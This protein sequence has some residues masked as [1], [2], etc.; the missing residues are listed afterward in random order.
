MGLAKR[1]GEKEAAVWHLDWAVN[2]SLS[3]EEV[4]DIV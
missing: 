2:E 4:F 3:E 1:E